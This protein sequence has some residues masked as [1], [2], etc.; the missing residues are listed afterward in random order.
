MI[1]RKAIL[2]L[3]AS[4]ILSVSL[5]AQR[6]QKYL[7]NDAIAVVGMDLK[8]LDSKVDFEQISKLDM[9][10]TGLEAAE[11]MSVMTGGPSPA[12]IMANPE[13]YGL[14]L[15]SKSYLTISETP[16]GSMVTSF[17]MELSD[18][19]KFSGFIKNKMKLPTAA[20]GDVQMA[21]FDEMGL[22]WNDE[23][24][25]LAAG[26]PQDAA[27]SYDE[28]PGEGE[29]MP[30]PSIN[31]GEYMQKALTQTGDNM[32][33]NSVFQLH[34]AKDRDFS[35]WVNYAKFSEMT[36]MAGLKD[37]A[38]MGGGQEEMMANMLMAI[39]GDLYQD[40]YW[41]MDLDFAEGA[42]EMESGMQMN[43][44]LYTYAKNAVD[45]RINKRFGK[46]VK[47]DGLL[48]YYAFGMNME[49]TITGMEDI[50]M[51]KI[52]NIPM[53][54]DWVQSGLD[55]LS[56]IIDEEALY[57]LLEG[58]MMIAFSGLEE[59]TM[60]DIQYDEE[61]NPYETTRTQ[62]LPVF[63]AMFSFG[64]EEN[65]RKLIRLGENTSVLMRKNDNI[66][67]LAIPGEELPMDIY[68]ALTKDFLMI[69]S[70]GDLVNN[71]LEKG[72]AGSKRLAKEHRKKLKKNMSALY[73]D[74][75]QLMEAMVAISPSVEDS[76]DAQA[77]I[78]GFQDTFNS[79]E[80]TTPRTM[81]NP[82]FSSLK[83]TFD[84]KDRNSLE[85]L[86]NYINEIFLRVGPSLS[87]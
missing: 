22:A 23:V 47:Q 26:M 55:I 56:I 39:L 32:L 35:S 68:V 73:L 62:V 78:K 38:G 77:M 63:N 27:V 36:Q 29:E 70:D 50:F 87:M 57:H 7:S 85:Q 44:Q 71:H 14:N 5:S 25:M 58:D 24:L 72:Y 81:S 31:I 46:Y 34:N 37:M 67:K 4:F 33:A 11:M 43:D 30:E 17:F 76:P 6:I 86:M 12:D 45:T 53:I 42:L 15:I 21:T 69:T 51:P 79:L 20:K 54:G 28:F 66:F 2:P 18:A 10:K 49:N 48:G 83:L 82:S 19:D 84:N 16:D 13:K 64:S 1:N 9:I 40:T 60:K 8:N 61:F 59:Y 80:A 52:S 65:I 41:M 75:D 74:V 3:L